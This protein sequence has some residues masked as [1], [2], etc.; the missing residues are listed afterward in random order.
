MVTILSKKATG[1]LMAEDDGDESVSFKHVERAI[2]EQLIPSDKAFAERIVSRKQRASVAV[3]EETAIAAETA[4]KISRTRLTASNVF[5]RADL[6][7]AELRNRASFCTA[8]KRLRN[9]RALD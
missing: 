9:F 2:S 5:R 6:V 8:N 7:S 1:G 4:E 3:I